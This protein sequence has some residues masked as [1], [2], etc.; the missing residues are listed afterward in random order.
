MPDRRQGTQQQPVQEGKHRR[1]GA[2]AQH[3]RQERDRGKSR[4]FRQHPQPEAR[5]PQQVLDPGHAEGSMRL[6]FE[7]RGSAELEARLALR[8]GAVA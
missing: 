8:L 7:T 4:R 5:I 3:Q 2:D 1:R 6:L